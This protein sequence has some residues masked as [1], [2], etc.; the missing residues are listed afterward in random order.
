[1]IEDFE[2][3]C[4][5]VRVGF[6]WQVCRKSAEAAIE[7]PKKQNRGRYNVRVGFVWQVCRKSAEAAIETPERQN[8]GRYNVRVGCNVKIN[9]KC[10]IGRRMIFE[11]V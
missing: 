8:R 4:Y 3:K 2:K 5:N 11:A 10:S 6:V 9:I 1:M 7:T